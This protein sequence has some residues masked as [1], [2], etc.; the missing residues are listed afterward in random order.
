MFYFPNLKLTFQFLGSSDFFMS[1][2][3]SSRYRGN[4]PTS[5]SGLYTVNSIS[6]IFGILKLNF[7]ETITIFEGS[8]DS[9]LY[10]NSVAI[11]TANRDIPFDSENIQYC[12]DYDTTGIKKS[13][14]RFLAGDTVF[15]WKLFLGF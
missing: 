7:S 9:F 14:E 6:L 8:L 4:V 10:Y 13:I 11:S 15:L 3:I 1:I 5:K 2:S 12:Y